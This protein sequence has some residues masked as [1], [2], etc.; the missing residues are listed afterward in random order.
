M[1][2]YRCNVWKWAKT[3]WEAALS[4]RKTDATVAHGEYFT[5]YTRICMYCD[6]NGFHYCQCNWLI[7]R[8]VLAF[9]KYSTDV[10]SVL[11]RWS[12]P[13]N[14]TKLNRAP[15]EDGKSKILMIFWWRLSHSTGNDDYPQLIAFCF[16]NFLE[17]MNSVVSSLLRFF[18]F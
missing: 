13:Y 2:T 14:K 4:K 11:F 18:A 16:P 1:K 3:V 10:T 5:N 15:V 9:I 7:Q 17:Q 12:C 6:F 8:N